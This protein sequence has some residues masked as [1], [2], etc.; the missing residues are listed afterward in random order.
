MPDTDSVRLLR[1]CDAGIKMGVGSIDDVSSY[2]SDE[3]LRQCL[4]ESKRDHE[5][6]GDHLRE[7]LDAYGDKGKDPN[8][9]AQSMSWIKTNAKLVFDRSDSVIADLITD[10]CNMGV[11]SLRR[12]LNQYKAADDES[13]AIAKR[14]IAVE[15]SLADN[16]VAYL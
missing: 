7:R 2:V 14:L 4:E 13:R 9:A 6:L 3:K 11:K 8:V 16:M 1:E 15:R 10:G 12:Y 5:I